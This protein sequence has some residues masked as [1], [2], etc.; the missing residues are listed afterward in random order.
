VTIDGG[1]YGV[2]GGGGEEPMPVERGWFAGGGIAVAASAG[3]Q[4]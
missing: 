2:T 4:N 1:D 3:A